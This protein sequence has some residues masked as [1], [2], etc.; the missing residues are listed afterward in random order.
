MSQKGTYHRGYLPHRDYPDAL[1]AITFRLA[2]SMPRKVVEAWKEELS[3][4][5][6]SCDL[7]LAAEARRALRQRIARYEDKCLGSCLLRDSTNAR[8]VQNQL[9]KR[10]L[11]DYLLLSW[12]IMPN[13][14]HVLIRLKTTSLARLVGAW[15]GASAFAINRAR[16]SSGKLWERDYFD[17]AIN[18]EEHFY[19]SVN[20][21]HHNP[22]KAGLCDNPEDWPFSSAGLDWDPDKPT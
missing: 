18:T 10:H 19:R 11:K 9:I 20:Y 2:D 8:I 5:L 6:Q 13:H 15:K 1:Q 14:V 17:R 21:I 22:V 12:C 7:G 3:L 4:A 16:G